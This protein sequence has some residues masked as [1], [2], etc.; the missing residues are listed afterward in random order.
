MANGSLRSTRT[1][2]RRIH[3]SCGHGDLVPWGCGVLVILVV[4]VDLLVPT[5]THASTDASSASSRPV[6]R[7]PCSTLSP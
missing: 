7:D 2:G 6:V 4:T 3:L 1:F 5:A